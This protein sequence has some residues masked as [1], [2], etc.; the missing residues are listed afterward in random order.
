MPFPHSP[1]PLY[2]V[3]PLVYV[4]G[5]VSAAVWSNNAIGLVSGLALA[6]AGLHLRVLRKRY[7]LQHAE[8]RALIEARLRRARQSRAG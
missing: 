7:R 1:K 6:V 8:R 5:G 3:L 2:E 4:V